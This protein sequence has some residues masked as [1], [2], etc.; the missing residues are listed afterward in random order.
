VVLRKN[1]NRGRQ[2]R[3]RSI[4]NLGDASGQAVIVVADKRSCVLICLCLEARGSTLCKNRLT[5]LRDRPPDDDTVRLVIG[6]SFV[7]AERTLMPS[8]P[9]IILILGLTAGAAL[10]VGIWLALCGSR[11][12]DSPGWTNSPSWATALDR[13]SARS[14]SQ[15]KKA[16]LPC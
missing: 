12:A 6:Q 16:I 7:A 3:P 14:L 9:S 13:P 1:E 15:Q 8:G 2:V 5:A 11:R 4:S 10:R